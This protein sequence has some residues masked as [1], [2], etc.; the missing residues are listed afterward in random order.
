MAPGGAALLLD[1][2][3]GDVRVAILQIA[4]SKGIGAE[5][6]DA[7]LIEP[8]LQGLPLR[9]DDPAADVEFVAADEEGALDVLLAQRE[10]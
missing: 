1:G 3:I 6:Q 10:P 5:S 2:A 9:H 7:V 8:A 4:E